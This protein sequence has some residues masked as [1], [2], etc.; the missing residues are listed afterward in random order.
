MTPVSRSRQAKSLLKRSLRDS[1]TL[2]FAMGLGLPV[3][4]VVLTPDDLAGTPQVGMRVPSFVEATYGPG[5][6]EWVRQTHEG[7]LNFGGV[8]TSVEEL[9]GEN[10]TR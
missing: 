1:R 8:T 2:S 3:E 4:A 9:T 5:I 10:R 6:L 7:R